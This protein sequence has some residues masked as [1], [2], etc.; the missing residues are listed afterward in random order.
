[1]TDLLS[2]GCGIDQC[3]NTI[4]ILSENDRVTAYDT[5]NSVASPPAQYASGMGLTYTTIISPN[6]RCSLTFNCPTNVD[7]CWLNISNTAQDNMVAYILYNSTA[8]TALDI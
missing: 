1:M 6:N 2:N 5:A 3:T 4:N 8:T 7:S